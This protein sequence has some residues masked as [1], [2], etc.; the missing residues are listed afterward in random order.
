MILTKIDFLIA[1]GT[2]WHVGSGWSWSG[3]A[4]ERVKVDEE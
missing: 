2:L 3:S 4:G 1:F